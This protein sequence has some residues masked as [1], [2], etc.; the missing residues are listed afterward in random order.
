MMVF[1]DAKTAHRR[2]GKAI[3][4]LTRACATYMRHGGVNYAPGRKGF[5]WCCFPGEKTQ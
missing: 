4:W 2:Q 5:W 3:E 1:G